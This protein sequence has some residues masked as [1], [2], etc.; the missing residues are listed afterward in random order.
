MER[1]FNLLILSCLWLQA[2]EGL[3]SCKQYVSGSSSYNTYYCEYYCC[4]SLYSNDCCH[5]DTGS[6]SSSS[7]R[8]AVNTGRIVLYS[9]G[10]IVPF[11]LLICSCIV[12]CVK[13][14]TRVQP[15]TLNTVT[16]GKLPS[17]PPYQG[18]TVPPST[19]TPPASTSAQST[20]PG[21]VHA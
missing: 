6:S 4:G 13:K 11:S 3:Q 20:L 9:I 5:D 1:M 15:M 7:L 17:I 8:N 12:V 19:P 18:T 21:T 2:C 10:G 14:K 16:T